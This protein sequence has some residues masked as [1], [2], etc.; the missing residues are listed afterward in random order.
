[1]PEFSAL[2]DGYYRFRAGAYS[3]QKGRYDSLASK[4]QA[5]PVMIIGCSDSRVDPATIF[6]VVPGQ[7]FALRNV[8]NLVPPYQPGQGLHGASAAIEFAVVDLKV[9]HIVVMGHGACGGI[10]A[11]LEGGDRGMAGPS[12]ID[13]WMEIVREGRDRVLKQVETD[14]HLD[15]QRALELESVRISIENLR[16]F[17]YVEE[18]E[19]EGRLKLHGCWFAIA[20][21][22][23]YVLDPETGE[24]GTA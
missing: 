3:A 10:K 16:T 14:P 17:P 8:A 1:M 11:A 5:P 9:R 13:D 15:V 6:D 2:I 4:G 12:F 24:F 19:R 7:I 20:E 21:G 23:L 18:A 22:E